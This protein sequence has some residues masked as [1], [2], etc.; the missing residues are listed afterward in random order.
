MKIHEHQA[1]E[2]LRKYQ[3]AV[4]EGGVAF[5]VDEAVQVYQRLGGGVCAVKSQIHAG[6]RGKG[7]L[8]D[9]DDNSHLIM[10]G[11]VK[12]ARSQ[13]EVREYAGN[14]LGNLLITHQTARRA[15]WYAEF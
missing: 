10:E 2:I 1:K 13:D 8:Y 9:P 11:G 3:V 6:G 7:S 14:I 5:S 4:P 15:R 12:I